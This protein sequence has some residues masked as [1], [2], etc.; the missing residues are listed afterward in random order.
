MILI[1]DLNE[2]PLSYFEF[3]RPIEN[4]MKRSSLKFK[5]VN[6]KKI[7]KKHL[8]NSE[9]IILTGTSIKNN[10]YLK[11]DFSYLRNYKNPVLGICAGAE[12]ISLTFGGKLKKLTEIG[13]TKLKPNKLNITNVYS[14][15]NLSIT[16]PEGFKII[17]KSDKC[18]QTIKKGNITCHQFHPEVLNEGLIADFSKNL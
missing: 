3:V 6:Y 10:K 13:I 16:P 15:H 18:P 14:L 2:D 12:I 8:Q 11:H 7:T 9:K 5:T 4:I 1:I 17:L